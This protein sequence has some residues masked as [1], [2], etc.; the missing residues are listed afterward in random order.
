[1]NLPNFG[2]PR[3]EILVEVGLLWLGHEI[4]MG[5]QD[6]GIVEREERRW[7]KFSY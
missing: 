4:Y 1:M 2:D 6:I 7:S 5:Y 3:H